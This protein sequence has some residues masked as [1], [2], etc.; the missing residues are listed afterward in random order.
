M[1][2]TF[3]WNETANSEGEWLMNLSNRP[4]QWLQE[5]NWESAAKANNDAAAILERIEFFRT[6]MKK[7]L[8]ANDYVLEV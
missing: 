1:I 4:A 5:Q 8:M 3:H 2:I 6:Q 7:D